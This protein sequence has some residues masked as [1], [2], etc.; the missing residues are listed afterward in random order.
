MRNDD[1]SER[2]QAVDVLGHCSTAVTSIFSGSRT[3]TSTSVMEV[4][5]SRPDQL[6]AK[7]HRSW[8]SA[9]RFFLFTVRRQ[10][11]LPV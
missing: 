7:T 10:V 11:I 5:S 4:V 1:C 2:G 9:V 6:N 3:G 8:T